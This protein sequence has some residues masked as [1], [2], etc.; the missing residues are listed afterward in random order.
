MN[1]MRNVGNDARLAIRLARRFPLFTAVVI[2]TVALG[3]GATT[4]IFS[5]VH[6]V[7]LQPLPFANSDRLVSLWGTNPDKS[8]PRFGVSWPDFRDW[9]QRTQ[10]FDDMAMYVGGITT[11]VAPEGPESVADLYVSA[12]FLDVLGIKPLVGRGFGA[13]DTR[14]E[15]SNAVILSYGYWQRRFGGDR[16]VIGR[17]VRVS[18]RPRTII[19]VLPASAQLLGPAFTGVPVDV[20]TVIELTTYAS[21]ERHAQHLFGAIGRLEPRVTLQQARSDLYRTEVQVAAENAEIAGWTASAFYVTDDLSLGIKEPLLI[22][23]AASALLLVIACINVA[24]LLLVRGAARSREIAVRRAL[25]A[26]RGRLTGQFVV[27][28]AVLALT[29]GMLGV[30]IASMAVRAIRE[31]LPFGVVARAEDIRMSAPVL[32]FALGISLVAAIAFGVWPA[33]RREGSPRLGVELRD[34][35]QTAAKS[36]ARRSFVVAEFALALILLVCAALVGQSV[37]RMLRVDPGFR[38][39]HV[40]TASLTLGKDYP[41]SAAVG[42]YRAFLTDLENRPGVEAAGAT[43]TPPLGGGGGIFTSIRLIGEPPRPPDQPLMSTIRS[44][45]PGYF[46][47]LGIRV[48]AGHDLEWNEPST[49]IVL[50]KSA[51]EAFWR[52]RSVVG[53][54]IG[55]NTQPATYPIVGEASDTRQTSLATAPTPIVYASMR[56]YVRVFHTMILVVRGRGEVASTVA[57]IRSALHDA[58][59]KL[60]L[61]NVQTMQSIVDQSTAQPRL[62]IVLL[63]AFAS[64]AL[65]LATLGVYGVVSYAVSQRVREIG[66][67]MALGASASDVTRMILREGGMLAMIGIS[68]GLLGSLFATRFIGSMLFELQAIDVP[69]FVASAGAMLAVGLTASYVPARRAARV[70]PVRAMRAE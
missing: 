18:G 12:N 26:S 29:G 57:T 35:A 31:M 19:G 47:A 63:G 51:A 17:T 21:V 36:A 23:L 53:K 46:R 45:T 40:V 56:R 43:D 67:R 65:L 59:P 48:V 44:V 2:L 37:R 66:V 32:G 24:N 22:L 70:D 3:V 5:A 4:A 54:Q 64:V 33:I 60:S 55:F 34:R 39:D 13:D 20:M 27:E 30:G 14:G 6:A 68:V 52:G 28:S 61:Y 8:V 62:N 15:S 49:S 41:D 7:M 1:T 38:S 42:F 11:L 16:A 10:S 69:T 9:K 50:S 58:D 25:G